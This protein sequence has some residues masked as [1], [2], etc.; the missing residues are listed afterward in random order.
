[1]KL[2]EQFKRISIGIDLAYTKKSHSDYSCA[3]VLGSSDDGNHFVLDV[4][5]KQCEVKDFG[6]ILKQLRMDWGSPTIWWFVGGQEK[7]IADFLLN[8][9]KVPIKTLPAK[10]DKFAR[11][12]AVASAWNSGKIWIPSANKPWVSA[13][14]SE[15]LSFSGLDDPHDDQVDA[16]AAAYIPSAMKRSIVGNL[17][18]QILSF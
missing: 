7:V 9:V 12:Q 16:L 4:I 11:A 10:E 3:V 5:R 8:T 13:F 1:M 2:P 18:R 14:T 6:Q 17:S 15:V